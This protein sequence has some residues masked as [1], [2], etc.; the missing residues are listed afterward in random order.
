MMLLSEW[1]RV[2]SGTNV[3]PPT[4]STRWASSSPR[5]GRRRPGRWAAPAGVVGGRAWDR[6]PRGRLRLRARLLSRRGGSTDIRRSSSTSA[7]GGMRL[8]TGWWSRCGSPRRWSCRRR[9]RRAHVRAVIFRR[10]ECSSARPVDFVPRAAVELILHAAR[11]LGGSGCRSGAGGPLPST[12]RAHG[13]WPMWTFAWRGPVRPMTVRDLLVGS[14][15][16]QQSATSPMSVI[17]AWF[18]RCMFDVADH[19]DSAVVADGAVGRIAV[20]SCGAASSAG[21]TRASVVRAS[22]SGSAST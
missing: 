19:L 17:P 18:D 15:R 4:T 10:P 5:P 20:R 14:G 9:R 21:D 12:V 6:R 11:R 8:R 16:A 3:S 13:P 2:R 1:S 7:S 22:T